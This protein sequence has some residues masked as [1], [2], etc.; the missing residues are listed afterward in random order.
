MR[1]VVTKVKSA[2]VAVEG[3][4]TQAI[5]G[6]LLV[7]LGSQEGDGDADIAYI[8][9]KVCNLRIFEDSED[10]MNLSLRDVGGEILVVFAVYAAG[11]RAQGAEAELYSCGRS[12]AGRGHLRPRG[13]GVPKTGI[14]IKTGTFQAHMEV[15][16][17]NDGP[18]TILLDSRKLF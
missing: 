14:G 16:S 5:E 17:V 18:V 15:A 10:K 11:R 9:D 1:A 6:G 4:E 7:L 8:V 3:K 12:G 2:S 13:G